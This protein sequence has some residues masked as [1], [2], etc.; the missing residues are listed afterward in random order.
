MVKTLITSTLP[1]AVPSIDLHFRTTP[2]CSVYRYR[3]LEVLRTAFPDVP[4]LALTATAT[5][6]VVKDIQRTLKVT[7]AP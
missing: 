7:H 2:S 6:N 4:L 1:E 5:A 3:R